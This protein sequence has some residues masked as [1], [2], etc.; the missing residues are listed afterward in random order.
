MCVLTLTDGGPYFGNLTDH[1]HPYKF[2][3]VDLLVV[4]VKV[5]NVTED[6]T[7][8]VGDNVTYACSVRF[9]GPTIKFSAMWSGP[10]LTSQKMLNYKKD[11][12][13]HHYGESAV[14]R[15]L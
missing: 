10:G 1:P 7:F 12:H 5:C 11:R 13:P 2:V 14:G 15:R 4:E 9:R 8:T 6:H 3:A